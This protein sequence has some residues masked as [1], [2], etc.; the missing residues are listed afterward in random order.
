MKKALPFIIVI[1]F[2]LSGC[3]ISHYD[4]SNWN[5]HQLPNGYSFQYPDSWKAA[6]TENNLLYLYQD[7]EN[8]SKEIMVFQSNSVPDIDLGLEGIVESNA[9]SNNFKSIRIEHIQTGP[10]PDVHYGIDK[11][12]A[13][14]NTVNL[15][16][17]IFYTQ[18]DDPNDA[19]ETNW[20]IKL[21]FTNDVSDD[22]FR[23][24]SKSCDY[25]YDPD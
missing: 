23:Q 17:L 7:S 24:I 9:Y 1:L 6:F 20:G 4:T 11:V 2:I 22:I 8:G 3:S 15:K 19:D 13:N 16:Y 12:S 5:T 10:I 25:H 21:F 18:H 14:K